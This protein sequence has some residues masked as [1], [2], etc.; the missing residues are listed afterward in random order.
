MGGTWGGGTR[1][2]QA[3]APPPLQDPATSQFPLPRQK[4]DAPRAQQDVLGD[5][6]R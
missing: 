6:G 1:L 4:A 3:P 5:S 2:C